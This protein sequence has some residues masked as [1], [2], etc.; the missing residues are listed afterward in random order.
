MYDD[1]LYFVFTVSALSDRFSAISLYFSDLHSGRPDF[2][3]IWCARYHRF[4]RGAKISIVS[5]RSAAVLLWHV[6]KVRILCNRSASLIRTTRI[7]SPSPER[8]CQVRYVD[9]R[10]TRPPPSGYLLFRHQLW[11]FT[12]IHSS[13]IWVLIALELAAGWL[14]WWR[15][16]DWPLIPNSVGYR[17]MLHWCFYS[18]W[19]SPE[20]TQ[21]RN[22]HFCQ[23][24]SHRTQW[25]CRFAWAR[26]WPSWACSAKW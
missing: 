13:F 11:W 18:M 7:S 1:F 26:F 16:T 21:P 23:N 8:S 17:S 3:S 12:I 19:S 14:I 25:W 2:S 24:S 10:R 22:P 15:I 6:A 5:E 20:T 4:A 9:L